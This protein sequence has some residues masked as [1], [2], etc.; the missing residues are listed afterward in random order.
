[1]LTCLLVTAGCVGVLTGAEPLTFEAGTASVS[2]AAQE[3]AGYEEVR[4]DVQAMTREVSAAGQTREVEVTNHLVEYSRS[5]SVATVGAG[6]L[7]RLV[8]LTTPAVEVLGRTF[9][10]VGDLSNR[11]LA[12]EVQSQYDGL[13]SLEPAGERTVDVLDTR[14]TLSTFTGEATVG[15]TGEAVELTLHVTRIRAGGDFL[16]VIAVHPSLLDETNRVD[17]MLAGLSHDS[18]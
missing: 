12:E 1:M 10:P 15:P 16:V 4:R 11:E 6:E 2:P 18:G 3:A 13:G 17:T 5:A 7:A 8:I 14:A 9:N